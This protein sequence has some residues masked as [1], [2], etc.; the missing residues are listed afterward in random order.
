MKKTLIYVV[1]VTALI[2]TTLSVANATRGEIAAIVNDSVITVSD[3]NNRIKL[4]TFGAKTKIPKE[5]KEALKQEV[6]N[7][8]IDE[9]IQLQEAD[10]LGVDITNEQLDNSFKDIAKKN[11][12]S[13]DAMENKLRKGGI[14]LKTLYDQLEAEISWSYVVR[15]KLRPKISISEEEIN[16]TLDKLSNNKETQYQVAEILLLVPTSAQEKNIHSKALALIKE[17]KKGA[18][19]PAVAKK[20]SQAPGSATGGD[21]G[22]VKEGQI[23]AELNTALEQM[24]PGE[25][26]LP[27][28]SSKGYHILLLRNIKQASNEVA[29][30][31]VS[32]KSRNIIASQLGTQRLMQ[33]AKHYLNDLRSIAFIEKRI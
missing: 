2:L 15:R 14:N 10:K 8:L 31:K 33:M 18:P 6:L 13:A 26:S 9:S 24:K 27:I 21:L 19:F 11:K 4:Y 5:Q 3:V 20:F 30:D 28:R 23:S 7:R 22:W 25:I 29:E 1:A 12:L 17:I 16:L 32:E